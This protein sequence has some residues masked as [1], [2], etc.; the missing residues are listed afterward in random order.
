MLSTMPFRSLP[1]RTVDAWVAVEVCR[2]FPRALLWGP[3]Q[4]AADPNWDYGASLGDGKL[5]IFEDKATDPIRVSR[6][7]PLN[8]HRIAIDL[9][10]L[11]WYC[12][13]IEPRFGAPVFYVLPRPS[14]P[15][16]PTPGVVPAQAITRVASP[17]GPF[18]EW[19]FV[20]R[21]H[22][23]RAQLPSQPQKTR[24][25]RTE[26]LPLPSSV[27]LSTFLEQVAACQTPAQM[28]KTGSGDKGLAAATGDLS[29]TYSD[30]P[31][32][33]VSTRQDVRRLWQATAVFIPAVDLPGWSEAEG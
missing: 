7:V 30:A 29:P 16:E 14:F 28:R 2:R 5:L 6:P 1:E 17:A 24:Q 31:D 15:G 22:D 11:A 23:L 13:E 4:R 12:D 21:C 9:G 19:A 3:T 8:T 33:F 26:D 18:R 20:I 10:Q 32:N 27:S 25:I